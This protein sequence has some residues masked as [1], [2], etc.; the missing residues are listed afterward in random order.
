MIPQQTSQQF[1]HILSHLHRSKEKT[2]TYSAHCRDSATPSFHFGFQKRSC[3]C[4]YKPCTSVDRP[5]TCQY[6]SCTFV[7]GP[8]TCQYKPCTSVDRPCT[9]QYKPCTFVDGPCTCQ[10]KSCTFVDRPCTCQYKSCT[11][12]D[13]PSIS[14]LSGS[15]NTPRRDCPAGEVGL[16]PGL[17]GGFGLGMT[18]AAAVAYL[19]ADPGAP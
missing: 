19:A 17:L 8:C 7:D 13:G 10:Y 11:L 12:V 1:I 4:R 9:C 18:A 3:I 2:H 6:K 5:S 14:A 16:F 15:T